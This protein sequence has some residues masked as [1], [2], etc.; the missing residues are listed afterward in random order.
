MNGLMMLPAFIGG[1]RGWQFIVVVLLI[2]L[3]FGGK[4]LPGLMRSL[5]KSVHSFKQGMEEA[6]REANRP[7]DTT[8]T[9]AKDTDKDGK[10]Q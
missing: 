6:R 5:G 1:M 3:F 9:A 10:E 2:L 7:I 4:R 8:D